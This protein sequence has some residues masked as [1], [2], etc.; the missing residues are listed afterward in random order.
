MPPIAW[1]DDG[2]A[3]NECPQSSRQTLI[4][5]LGDVLF[6]WSTA[7]LTALSSSTFHSVI[8]TP[9][10]TRLECG[11]ISE[12]EALE[13]IGDEL[14]LAPERIREA[15]SQCRN[16]LTVN[17]DLVAQLQALKKEMRGGVKVYAM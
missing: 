17:S 15:I 8:L 4:L 5:D 2:H 6:H 14:A 11:L 3:P 9:T 13:E 7:H 16:T 10:W 1:R 12:H